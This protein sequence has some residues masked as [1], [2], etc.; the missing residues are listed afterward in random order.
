MKTLSLALLLMACMAFVL[1]GC[2]DNSGSVSGPS[3]QAIPPQS[4]GSLAK[5]GRDMHSVTGSAHWRSVPVTGQTNA[6]YSF[7]AILHADG[8]ST[9]EVVTRD[10]GPIFYGH[11]R[12][13]D[14]KV[15]GNIGK[16]AFRFTRGN[17]NG[18]FPGD[19]AIDDIYG[20]CVVIDNGE[21]VNATGPD[22]VSMILFT[23][24]SDI[25]TGTIP[26]LDAMQ[27]QEFL[28]WMR[29]YLLPIYGVSY[30]EY[31]SPAD[32]GSVKVR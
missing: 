23:D 2:S 1:V 7:S 6:R 21:G 3:G 24:G 16:M 19:V 31:L 27:P 26:G 14:L 12:V 22:L 8:H 10:E 20:W 30:D 9:G 28:D 4:A 32:N 17:L 25:G 11:A 15:D 29:D 5:M 18:F 13:Y